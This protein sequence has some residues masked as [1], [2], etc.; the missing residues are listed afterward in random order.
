VRRTLLAIVVALVAGA[1]S[2]SVAAFSAWQLT[3]PGLPD[4]AWGQEL[5]RTLLPGARQ[6]VITVTPGI[7][8]YEDPPVPVLGGDDYYPGQLGIQA[9]VDSRP[10]PAAVLAGAGW[11]VLPPGTSGEVTARNGTWGLTLHEIYEDPAA[12]EVTVYRRTPDAVIWATTVAW[13]AG[14][15]LGAL[16]GMRADTVLRSRPP[17]RARLFLLGA[18]L[19]G[20]AAVIAT[21]SVAVQ[22][23]SAPAV[24]PVLPW[25]VY[26]YL[27][28]RPMTV[29]GAVLLLVAI[30]PIASRSRA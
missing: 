5:A 28:F 8:A 23:F 26:M 19:S 12:I 6:V 11:E 3:A 1:L 27:L 21:G 13:L 22:V 24:V 18:A 25:D 9:R 10:D 20:P 14:A 29:A 15:L 16:L 17:V 2:G 30:S 4:R 7:A